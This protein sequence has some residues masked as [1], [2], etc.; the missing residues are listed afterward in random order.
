MTLLVGVSVEEVNG[1]QAAF[2]EPSANRAKRTVKVSLD[3]E[4]EV[5]MPPAVK[6]VVPARV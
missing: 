6:A 3:A 2:M 4:S 1:I 5:R